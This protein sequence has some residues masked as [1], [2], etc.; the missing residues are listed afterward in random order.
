MELIIGNKNY[1]SWSLRAWFMLASFNVD[2]EET[3][4]PL[5]TD[6]FRNK[7]TALSPTGKVPALQDGDL[8]VWDSLAIC[9]YVNDHYLNGNAWPH[10]SKSRAIARAICCEMHAGF[11]ALRNEIPMNCRATRYVELSE[12]AQQDIA[13]I[14]DL[15]AALRQEH[16]ADG[17]WLFG[18]LSI[19][20]AMYAPVVSRF[21]TYGI[22]LSAESQAYADHVLNSET[23][24]TWYDAAL[25]ETLIVVED[26]AG[27]E[28]PNNNDP[29]T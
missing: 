14:D 8:Q 4:L 20:D 18:A 2:F 19:A 11:T 1:S 17:P 9:E 25:Q 28:L 3:V 6:E 29:A 27:T 10:N 22:P 26:E 12:Q 23:M 7:I 21:K 15:W 13:R 24:Q 5:F 16:K